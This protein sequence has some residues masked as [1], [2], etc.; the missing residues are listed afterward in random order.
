MKTCI[1]FDYDWSLINENSDTYLFK[2]LYSERPDI[3]VELSRSGV[4]WTQAVDEALQQLQTKVGAQEI[5]DV[6]SKVPVQE[7]MLEAIRFAASQKNCELHIV[8]DANTIFIHEMLK[9]HDLSS[10]F[11][12]V[13]SN[14]AHYD[15]DGR[16][17][18][19]PYCTSLHGCEWCPSNMCKGQIL[20]QVIEISKYDRVIYIGDG[21]G[22]FC[23]ATRLI[24]PNDVVL[25][26]KDHDRQ[27]GLIKRIAKHGDKVQARVQE[28][29]SGHDIAQFFT[30]LF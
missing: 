2:E 5:N 16:L 25:A 15:Q 13:F 1:I 27:Y 10:A 9:H 30:S 22:D 7:G 29:S 23:P 20:D 19:E 11:G 4:Q 21:N 26:R 3:V 18:V 14:K 6:I 28:W 8:S 17:R 12:H 24:G